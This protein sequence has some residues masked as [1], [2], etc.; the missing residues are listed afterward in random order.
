MFEI[1]KSNSAIHSVDTMCNVL[2]Y[3][4]VFMVLEAIEN[5]KPYTVVVKVRT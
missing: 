5:D 4:C 2:N 1:I 3:I